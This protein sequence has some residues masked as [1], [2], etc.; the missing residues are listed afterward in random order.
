MTNNVPPPTMLFIVQAR[1]QY[2]KLIG[3]DQEY[4]RV[5][6][7]EESRREVWL[8]RLETM[9]VLNTLLVLDGPHFE[10]L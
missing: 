10:F 6:V 5:G 4:T 3:A 7:M 1:L 9:A 8:Q 2:S